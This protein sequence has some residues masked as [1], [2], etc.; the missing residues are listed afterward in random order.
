MSPTSEPQAR[1]RGTG[2]K[3]EERRAKSEIRSSAQPARLRLGL[4]SCT[5]FAGVEL[6]VLAMLVAVILAAGGQAVARGQDAGD[7]ATQ[8]A[9]RFAWVDISID[10]GSAALAAYQ[11]E[12]SSDAGKFQI[13]GIEGGDHAAFH[14]PPYYDPA[15]LKA[16]R[17]ILAAFSTDD[18]LP[19]SSTRVARVHV[20]L[21]DA[22]P[23]Y[24]AT[25]K[26]AATA[27]GTTIPVQVTLTEGAQP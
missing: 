14:E 27:D 3:S 18:A 21:E 20:M 4:C 26:V 23:H 22:A 17:V 24:I 5:R 19:T 25:L 13:V 10:S 2:K 16:G 6:S 9:P 1:A 12:L 11:L 7:A 15:A 8:A